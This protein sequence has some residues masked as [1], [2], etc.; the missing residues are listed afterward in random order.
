MKESLKGIV[1]FAITPFCEVN[2]RTMVDEDGLR[3]NVEFLLKHNVPVIVVCGGTGELWSL[4]DEERT[5]AVRAAV[6]QARGRALVIAGVEGDTQRSVE[7][8][9]VVEELGADGALLFPDDD[10]VDAGAAALLQYY[11]A[12]NDAVNVGIM[13]FRDDSISLASLQQLAD[14][15]NVVAIKEETFNIVAHRQVVLALGERFAIAG[16]GDELLPY[17]FLAGASAVCTGLSNFLPAHYVAMSDAAQRGDFQRVM[18]LHEQLEPLL[19]LREQHGT[20]LLKAAMEEVGLAGGAVRGKPTHL[21]PSAREE[22]RDVLK[23]VDG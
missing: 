23:M 14:L 22:L 20:R 17:Y 21:P 15:P 19:R 5:Q 18:E 8:A 4:E 16:A 11:R 6:E 3:G 2:R 7:R 12:V 10:I 1:V 13:A 9:R